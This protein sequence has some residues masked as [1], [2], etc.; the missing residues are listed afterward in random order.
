MLSIIWNARECAPDA[1]LPKLLGPADYKV[2]N[3]EA[4]PPRTGEASVLSSDR[5]SGKR[6]SEAMTQGWL[7]QS[8]WCAK[9]RITK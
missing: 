3:Q 2:V 6:R 1:C 5:K 9:T 8:G 4:R 7:F